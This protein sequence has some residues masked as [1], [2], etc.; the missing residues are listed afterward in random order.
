MRRI[1][2][3][4]FIALYFCSSA[5]FIRIGDTIPLHKDAFM[6]AMEQK[7]TQDKN[8][9]WFLPDFTNFSGACNVIFSAFN[10]KR[11]KTITAMEALDLVKCYYAVDFE[12]VDCDTAEHEETD[13]G[14]SQYYYYKLSWADYYLVYEKTES[15]ETY[16]LIH[17][18]EFVIDEPETGIGHTVTYGW[19]TVDKRTGEITEQ[20]Q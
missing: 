6:K 16:Y 3:C 9:A 7:I 17:L 19:Y 15:E 5:G 13:S 4:L 8:F 10:Y 11:E 2:L 18:Y 20:L 14:T 12:R 1:L